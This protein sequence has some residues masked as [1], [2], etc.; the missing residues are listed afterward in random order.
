MSKGSGEGRDSRDARLLLTYGSRRDSP[1]ASARKRST[2]AWPG[3]STRS[4]LK[5]TPGAW[6]ATS[7][8]RAPLTHRRRMGR[9]EVQMFSSFASLRKVPLRGRSTPHRPPRRSRTA[10]GPGQVRRAR[11]LRELSV[12][13]A[14]LV[15]GVGCE[16]G[17]GSTSGSHVATA[18]NAETASVGQ[19]ESRV[20]MTVGDR[21]FAITMADTAAA[22]AFAVQLP[23]ALEMVELNGNPTRTR[24]SAVWMTLPAWRRRS[25]RAAYGSSS[26][27]IDL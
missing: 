8:H 15:A 5:F 21:R 22:R 20:W 9:A 11:V 4:T 26:P 17:Q 23:L 24:G 7:P 3:A 19:E 27:R 13:L 6:K 1:N 14:L 2:T 16:A 10:S 18:A 25:A 12:L